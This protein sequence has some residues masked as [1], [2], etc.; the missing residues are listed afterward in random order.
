MTCQEAIDP[1]SAVR[2][3][4]SVLG[5]RW[6][7]MIIDA[8]RQGPLSFVGLRRAVSGISDAMLSERLAELASVTIVARTVCSGPPVTVEYSLTDSGAELLPTLRTLGDWA[9]RNL[10]QPSEAASNRPAAIAS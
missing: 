2:L 9:A 7:G 1:C 6:N 5:K 3:A 10:A 8:L 4:F